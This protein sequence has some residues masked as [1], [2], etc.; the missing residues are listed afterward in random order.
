MIGIILFCWFTYPINHSTVSRRYSGSRSSLAV[1]FDSFNYEIVVV[2]AKSIRELLLLLFSTLLLRLELLSLLLLSLFRTFY[3]RWPQCFTAN[4]CVYF[5][6]M[7][8]ICD[9][10]RLKLRQRGCYKSRVNVF[11]LNSKNRETDN[12][13]IYTDFHPMW[14]MLR[15]IT[16][17]QNKRKIALNDF[18]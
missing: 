13:H 10:R 17:E 8:V 11:R 3:L 18:T 5:M 9:S 14:W 6:R 15:T 4:A 7:C 1:L 16:H 12:T 2:I